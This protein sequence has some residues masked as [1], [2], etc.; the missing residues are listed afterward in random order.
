MDWGAILIV[1][2][3]TTLLVLGT[4]L[5]SWFS[6]IITAIKVGVVVLVIVVGFSTSGV[7]TSAPSFPPSEAGEGVHKSQWIRRC[8]R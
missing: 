5:S 6:A 4:R 7:T 8:S 2:V 1:A 3:V